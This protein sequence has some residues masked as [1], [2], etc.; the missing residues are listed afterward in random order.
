[1][2]HLLEKAIAEASKLPE[3]EQDRIAQWL[4]GEIESERL[5]DEAFQGSTDELSGLARKALQEHRDGKTRRLD[6]DEL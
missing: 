5:W 6:P 1:M 3:A 2:T 4:L